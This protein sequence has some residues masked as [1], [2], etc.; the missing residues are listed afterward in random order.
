MLEDS[1]KYKTYEG[2]LHLLDFGG[3]IIA[4]FKSSN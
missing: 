4:K 3:D 1:K 2:E